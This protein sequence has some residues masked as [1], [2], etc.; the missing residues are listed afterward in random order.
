VRWCP[1]RPTPGASSG[2]RP[3]GGWVL[4]VERDVKTLVQLASELSRRGLRVQTA[5]DLDEALETLQDEGEGCELV[6][7]AAGMSDEMT[8]AT[9]R[10]LLSRSTG[11]H[12]AVAVLGD[13]SAK[14]QVQGCLGAGAVEFLSKPID[15]DQLTALL[16]EVLPD[17]PVP[18]T[19]AAPRE[20][21]V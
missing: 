19:S 21:I 13:R 4:I 14:T 5:A 16:A 15:P 10:T 3:G 12:P 2:G 17:R 18:E 9:I 7:L 1:R 8:C 20:P 11:P 6:L